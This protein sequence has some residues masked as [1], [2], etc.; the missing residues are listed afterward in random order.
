MVD[1]D[2]WD[3]VCEIAKIKNKPITCSKCMSKIAQYPFSSPEFCELCWVKKQYCGRCFLYKTITSDNTNMNEIMCYRCKQDPILSVHAILPLLHP[4]LSLSDFVS[5]ISQITNYNEQKRISI[6]CRCGLISD[7]VLIDA[8]INPRYGNM[9]K[10]CKQ[11]ASE[12]ICNQ[13]KMHIMVAPL[14]TLILHFLY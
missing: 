10:M 6:C 12:V 9:L 3:L 13:M 2:D 4:V 11:C 14:C 7:E 8:Y 1:E 5:R